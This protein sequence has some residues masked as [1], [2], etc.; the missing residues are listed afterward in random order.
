MNGKCPSKK[1]RIE[2]AESIEMSEHQIY[3]WFWEAKKKSL[4]VDKKTIEQI[5][6]T[7]KRSGLSNLLSDEQKFEIFAKKALKQNK[8]SPEIVGFDGLGMPLE[9][10]EMLSAIKVHWQSIKTGT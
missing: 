6:Q 4:N 8:Y 2:M 9:K 1:Q 10:H 5:K 7:P 3:K